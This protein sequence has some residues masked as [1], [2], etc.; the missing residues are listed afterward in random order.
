MVYE[1]GYKANVLVIYAILL[2]WEEADQKLK[3]FKVVNGTHGRYVSFRETDSN[4]RV[5]YLHLSDITNVQA[6]F[7]ILKGIHMKILLFTVIRNINF[8]IYY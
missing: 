8:E 7:K 1:R 5:G 4:N 6:K 2:I 3:L